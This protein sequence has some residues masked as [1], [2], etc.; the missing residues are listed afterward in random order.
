MARRFGSSPSIHLPT[1]SKNH[2]LNLLLN[3][4]V[5]LHRILLYLHLADDDV[6]VLRGDGDGYGYVD[7]NRSHHLLHSPLMK[8]LLQQLSHHRS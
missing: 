8:N 1:R 2:L 3:L 6:P 4:P 7:L 5:N